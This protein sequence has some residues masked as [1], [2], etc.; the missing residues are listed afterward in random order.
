LRANGSRECAPD[1][2]LREAIHRAA[3]KKKEWI[4][5]LPPSLADHFR[6]LDASTEA[7]GP[8]VF[9]V[10]QLSSMRSSVAPPASTASR[11][12]FVTIAIRPL[13]WDE[14]AKD[15]ALILV[16]ENQKIFQKGLDR[17][18][19]KLP[20]RTNQWMKRSSK[21]Q[22]SGDFQRRN[23]LDLVAELPLGLLQ[24][25]SLLQIEPEIGTVATQLAEPQ[26]HDRRDRLLFPQDVIKRLTRHAEQ[27]AI[28]VL[29]RSST[30]KISSRSSSPDASA[31]SLASGAF[32][33]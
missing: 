26:R 16:S 23:V 32:W 29:G 18:I 3:R 15:I 31:A 11:P 4:A 27:L 21:S 24:I 30:G 8:H 12:A 5:F 22:L 1:D 10:R 25:I 6:K 17:P 9:A 2:R 19:E 33:S 7:S 28:S 13:E 20:D 14:T